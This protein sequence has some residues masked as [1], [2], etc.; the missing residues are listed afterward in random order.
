MNR[1]VTTNRHTVAGAPLRGAW[2]CLV[3]ALALACAAAF[4]AGAE[5]PP[6]LTVTLKALGGD[7]VAGGRS[8]LGVVYH[9]PAGTHLTAT[10][11]GLVFA[12]EPA[13][14]FGAA[15]FPNPSRPRSPTT[16]ARSWRWCR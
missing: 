13:A 4:P 14:A 8:R 1:R 5:T 16:A 9:V 11:Q 12:S 2:T 10:F 6:Q 3:L 15:V 7:P